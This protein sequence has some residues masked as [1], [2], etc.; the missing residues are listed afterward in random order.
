M[1][2]KNSAAVMLESNPAFLELLRVA[3]LFLLHT[4]SF[5]FPVFEEKNARNVLLGFRCECGKINGF[6]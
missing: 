3:P 5:L 6:S 1:S 2:N 4:H